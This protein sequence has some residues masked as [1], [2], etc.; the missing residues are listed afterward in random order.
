MN[1]NGVLAIMDDKGREK[2]RYTVVY[3]AKLKVEEGD[4]GEGRRNT[5]R[6]GSVHV[7]DPDRS[8]R[9]RSSSRT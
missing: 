3:G 9:A 5:G 8:Q 7:R 6:M 2:E 4:H 1:R